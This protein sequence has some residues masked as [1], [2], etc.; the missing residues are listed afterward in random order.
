MLNAL[1]HSHVN[2][3]RLAIGFNG[4][5]EFGKVWIVEFHMESSWLPRD[6]NRHTRRKWELTLP[7]IAS[8][9]GARIERLIVLNVRRSKQDDPSGQNDCRQHDGKP[10]SL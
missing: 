10:R 7:I 1:G 3:A 4:V 8:L 2:V 6:T 5:P 9:L